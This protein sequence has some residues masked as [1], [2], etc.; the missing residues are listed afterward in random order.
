MRKVVLSCF[1][2]SLIFLMACPPKPVL[3][4]LRAK[5]V[6]STMSE[7]SAYLQDCF[8]EN[9]VPGLVDMRIT[10]LGKSGEVLKV[11]I[12]GQFEGTATGKC[13]ENAVSKI[14]FPPFQDIT[15]V[16][17]YSVWFK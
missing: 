6:K 16:K 2:L 9:K 13:L 11:E 10:I 7:N 14:S 5:Q 17:S 15:I 4:T 12:T 8:I 1:G 3:P